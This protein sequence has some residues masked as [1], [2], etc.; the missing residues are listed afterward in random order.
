MELKKVGAEAPEK[1]TQYVKRHIGLDKAFPNGGLSQSTHILF[2]LFVSRHDNYAVQRQ[3]GDY[4]RVGKPLTLKV[5]RQHLEGRVTVGA[6]QLNAESMV[7]TLIFDLDPEKLEDPQLTA[8]TIVEECVNKPE[9]K[10]PRFYRKAVLLEASRHPDPSY[11]I[12]VFFQPVPVPA[13]V[14]RWL[15]FKVLE[16][17]NINPK[18]VEVFPKQGGLTEARPYGNFVKLPLGK[19]Q[20]HDKW[21][22]FLD[23]ETLEPVTPKCLFEIQGVS[24]LDSDIRRILGFSRKTHVQAKFDLPKNYKPMD[25]SEE[26]K[27]VR[28]LVKY[29]IKPDPTREIEGNRNKVEMAFLGWCLKRGVAHESARRIIQRVVDLTG[30]EEASSRLQLVDY[31]YKNRRSLGAELLGLSGLRKI[32][33]ETLKK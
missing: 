18:R 19:H 17:A 22:R 20:V 33:R 26:E 30:D 5:L 28:F 12:W 15:G 9:R 25:N 4:F 13:Q 10:K 14:A 29:W 6:Y 31:H 23:L 11:H 7:K 8:R 32:V 24:F 27:I 2:H 16:H 3:N 1:H 21:S